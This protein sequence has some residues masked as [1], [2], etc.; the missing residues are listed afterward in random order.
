MRERVSITIDRDGPG[1]SQNSRTPLR[2]QSSFQGL[3]TV[4]SQYAATSPMARNREPWASLGPANAESRR[5]SIEEAMP[6]IHSRASMEGSHESP[7]PGSQSSHRAIW[8]TGRS[9][10]LPSP[11]LD[12]SKIAETD[13]ALD[14]LRLSLREAIAD[15]NIPSPPPTPPPKLKAPSISPQANI[16][17]A[18]GA[19]APPP[20][21][22]ADVAAASPVAASAARDQHLSEQLSRRMQSWNGDAYYSPEHSPVCSPTPA[23][24]VEHHPL[25]STDD[26]T[27]KTPLGVSTSK[28]Q[29]QG[30]HHSADAT[31]EHAEESDPRFL[32]PDTLFAKV[33]PPRMPVWPGDGDCG[34]GEVGEVSGHA[35]AANGHTKWTLR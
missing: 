33:N 13:A 2:K 34:R 29:P 9:P 7:S 6:R 16:Q 31:S 12:I 35:D 8:E 30:T 4:T 19:T 32:S 1:V 3:H 25:E 22:P 23:T 24:C 5:A 21:S 26:A 11:T 28:T 18:N 27:S 14:R 15:S 20:A 10:S 17:H